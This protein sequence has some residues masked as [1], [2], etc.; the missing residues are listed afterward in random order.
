M[1]AERLYWHI[2][3]WEMDELVCEQTYHAKEKRKLANKHKRTE[4]QQAPIITI[5]ETTP[6][7][8]CNSSGGH[9]ESKRPKHQHP[10]SL[11]PPL[12]L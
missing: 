12:L 9:P 11:V 1:I 8:T 7:P 2:G 6:L 5:Q 10:L 4:E 3:Y